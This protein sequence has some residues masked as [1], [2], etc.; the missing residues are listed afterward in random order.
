MHIELLRSS[1]SLSHKYT[2]KKK[3]EW[4]ASSRSELSFTNVSGV[5]GGGRD[6]SCVVGFQ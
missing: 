5:V 3:L 6:I 2:L 1:L 4:V